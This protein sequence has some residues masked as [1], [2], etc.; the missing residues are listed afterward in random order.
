MRIVLVFAPSFFAWAKEIARVLKK[1]GASIAAI[2]TTTQVCGR[3]KADK[4]LSFERI[5]DLEALEAAWIS[6]PPGNLHRHEKDWGADMLRR[7]VIADRQIG[8]GYVTGGPL[9]DSALTRM[10]RADPAIVPRYV[11]G[12]MDYV[13]D[14]YEKFRP[15]AVLFYAV[16]GAPA[17][18][19]AEAAPRYGARFYSFSAAR[20]G[21]RVVMDDSPRGML[22]PVRRAFEAIRRNPQEAGRYE[23]EARAWLETFRAGL[24]TMPEYETRNRALLEKSRRP[25]SILKSAAVEA[26][27][28]AL[29]PLI[30]GQRPLRG[31]SGWQKTWRSIAFP[32]AGLWHGRAAMYP[33]GAG[34][35]QAPYI[36]Y[37]L[38]YDPESTTMVSAPY[39]TNQMAVIEALSKALPLSW[40]LVVKEHPS[41]LGRRPR[42]FYE[43]IRNIP[44]VLLAWPHESSLHLVRDSALTATITGTVAWEAMLLGRP[45]LVIG[46]SPFRA[47]GEGLT[48]CSDLAA[49]GTAIQQAVAAPRARDESLIAYIAALYR[50]SVDFPQQILWG[51]PDARTLAA[52]GELTDYVAG[53]LL[54]RGGKAREAA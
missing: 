20:V 34:L 53:V 11:A 54:G 35:R 9:P 5:D 44:G 4:S 42:G 21:A 13:T 29:Y 19:L 45:A 37:A 22:E 51:D 23:G 3:L 32:L 18:A 6:A 47:I 33:A 27:K 8:G 49:L 28:A 10:V 43:E 16:A 1:E 36:Y 17:L 50:E 24:D 7:L 48:C 40:R 38:H 2:C 25:F 41:M 14:L 30:R 52:H 39:H 31:E 15:G 26:A 12:L 46:D